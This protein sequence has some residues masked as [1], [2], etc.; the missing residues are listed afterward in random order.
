MLSTPAIYNHC[1]MTNSCGW[2]LPCFNLD[3]G[4]RAGLVR[5]GASGGRACEGGEKE[6]L[7]V[8]LSIFLSCICCDSCRSQEAKVEV[9]IMMGQIGRAHV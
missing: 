8:S 7:A 9:E 5:R 3:S 2:Y 6:I 4:F 1:T